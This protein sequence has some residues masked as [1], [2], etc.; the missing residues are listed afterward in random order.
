MPDWIEG[1]QDM[2]EA[3]GPDKAR[4]WSIRSGDG[5]LVRV[6]AFDGYRGREVIADF[7]VEAARALVAQIEA[8]IGGTERPSG[9]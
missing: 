9:D 1:E 7:P 2:P 6:A 5:P 4:A 8:A 3:A